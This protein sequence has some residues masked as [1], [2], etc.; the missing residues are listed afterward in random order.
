MIIGYRPIVAMGARAGVVRVDMEVGTGA[1]L[2]VE[3]VK[4]VVKGSATEIRIGR[5]IRETG[6]VPQEGW[7]VL[8]STIGGRR[9]RGH[10][11]RKIE[12]GG[13]AESQKSFHMEVVETVAEGNRVA[14]EMNGS[15]VGGEGEAEESLQEFREKAEERKRTRAG[16]GAKQGEHR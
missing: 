15:V 8:K 1:E 14:N 9:V 11:K 4:N 3:E 13:K 7:H 10:I 12:T 16:R 2:V 6:R 5:K